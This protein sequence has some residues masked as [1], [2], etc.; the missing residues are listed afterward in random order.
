MGHMDANYSHE[1]CEA[2]RKR[3]IYI[4]LRL[5]IEVFFNFADL[6][7][8]DPGEEYMKMVGKVKIKRK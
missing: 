4:V 6:I 7:G 8:S 3:Q 2:G 5:F 1:G